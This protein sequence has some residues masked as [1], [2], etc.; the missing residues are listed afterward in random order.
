MAFCGP[1]A[2]VVR[3]SSPFIDLLTF[4]LCFFFVAPFVSLTTPCRPTANDKAETLFTA[5]ARIAAASGDPTLAFDLSKQL[6]ARGAP[7][8][9]RS[10]VPALLGF[11]AAGCWQEALEVDAALTA[12]D[13]EL[14]E[15]EY[16]ALLQ[17]CS[18]GAPWER[19]KALLQRMQGELTVL[20]THTLQQVGWGFGE[21]GLRLVGW[22]WVGLG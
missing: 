5:M 12:V 9:L 19:V 7:P 17:A 21:I 4:N 13:L 3:R 2:L 22:N 8:R 15:G 14:T 11:C 16:G 20:S 1:C 18:R 10:Y 6:R